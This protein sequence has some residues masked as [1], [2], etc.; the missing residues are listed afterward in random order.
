MAPPRSRLRK[1]QRKK[2]DRTP[3]LLLSSSTLIVFLFYM[4]SAIIDDS[5][6]HF[7][8]TDSNERDM[9]G[10]CRESCSEVILTREEI[11]LATSPGSLAFSAVDAL[12]SF[13]EGDEED[14]STATI[15]RQKHGK[16]Q[17]KNTAQGKKNA[18]SSQNDAYRDLSPRPTRLPPLIETLVGT[19]GGNED[20]KML[21]QGDFTSGKRQGRSDRIHSP[22][23]RE[24]EI[25]TRPGDDSVAM[26][27]AAAAAALWSESESR[28]GTLRMKAFNDEWESSLRWIASWGQQ[29]HGNKA[30]VDH[31]SNINTSRAPHYSSK[32]SSRKHQRGSALGNEVRDTGH[33]NSDEYSSF[34]ELLDACV[35]QCTG[36]TREEYM[37]DSSTGHV[38][39]PEI[40]SNSG[41]IVNFS[42]IIFT[43]KSIALPFVYSSDYFRSIQANVQVIKSLFGMAVSTAIILGIRNI[44]D[45]WKHKTSLRLLLEEETYQEQIDNGR[46]KKNK[47]RIS[48]KKSASK[49][50]R[51]KRKEC[52]RVQK[53]H[54]LGCT[55]LTVN[56]EGNEDVSVSSESSN[57]SMSFLEDTR[58]KKQTIRN[59]VDDHSVDQGR[60]DHPS[61][62]SSSSCI[63]CDVDSEY[64]LIRGGSNNSKVHTENTAPAI[65]V[66]KQR[67]FKRKKSH[68]TKSKP[69]SSRERKRT[70]AQSSLMRNAT[71]NAQLKNK[72]HM[73]E[74][75]RFE[76]TTLETE[77]LTKSDQDA[78][79]IMTT[80]SPNVPTEEQREKASRLLREFQLTQVK[81]YIKSKQA[82]RSGSSILSPKATPLRSL[83]HANSYDE[84]EVLHNVLP[85]RPAPQ[86]WMNESFKTASTN[87]SNTPIST[88]IEDET[89]LDAGTDVGKSILNMLDESDEEAERKVILKDKMMAFSP[90]LTSKRL[91]VSPVKIVRK[92]IEGQNQVCSI[93]LGGLL[94]SKNSTST[95][96]S[97]NPWSTKHIAFRNQSPTLSFESC[98]THSQEPDENQTE[99]T[100]A[101]ICLQVSAR[102]FSP[103]WDNGQNRGSHAQVW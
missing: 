27:A 64:C 82:Q 8:N 1:Q 58:D 69:T 20:F 13:R 4:S 48:G 76:G 47:A 32:G 85:D 68:V 30:A 17:G 41:D 80:D 72:P 75:T 54:P 42:A 86:G 50:T 28:Q 46:H 103:S 11:L 70:L 102:E 49:R 84:V 97:S 25:P 35:A 77:S 57:E 99:Y 22:T 98:S 10:Q 19:I 52:N 15:K 34:S 60:K 83:V 51:R 36:G 23:G 91:L 89:N 67:K 2:I 90:V 43:L 7:D 71:Q 65:H 21:P 16:Q 45:W 26:V 53:S 12:F 56:C 18:I 74:F 95:S 61:L 9:V 96:V 39:V 55:I 6:L 78:V 63:P 101:N 88:H 29:Q 31:S 79:S 59:S 3:W 33:L 87:E 93:A 37:Q 66:L 24:V 73:P 92:S 38:N 5:D 14:R 81:K 40:E 94:A 44:T 62:T 100:D